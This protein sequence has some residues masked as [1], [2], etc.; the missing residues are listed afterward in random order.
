MSTT[1]SNVR[2]PFIVHLWFGIGQDLFYIRMRYEHTSAVWIG[3]GTG[4]PVC[5]DHSRLSNQCDRVPQFGIGI[6]CDAGKRT[7]TLHLTPEIS[8]V[9]CFQLRK[10]SRCLA[11]SSISRKVHVDWLE[12]DF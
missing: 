2:I 8:S 1:S 4:R 10:L 9:E 7:G 6:E 3:V 5:N 11:A 12:R